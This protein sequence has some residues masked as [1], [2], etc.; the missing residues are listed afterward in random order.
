MDNIE[1][2]IEE[3]VEVDEV[4]ENDEPME[5]PKKSK[6][7][8]SPLQI[9]AMKKAQQVRMLKVAE[10]RTAILQEKQER[11]E[12]VKKIQTKNNTDTSSSSEEELQS[13]VS[14]PKPKPKR[15]VK[16]KAP[17]VVFEDSESDEEQEIVIRRV[18]RNKK[19]NVKPTSPINIPKK[20]NEIHLEPVEE[21][22]EPIVE[23]KKFSHR[24]ILRA[25]GM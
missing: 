15:K 11:E 5:K 13:P 8:R 20:E 22:I 12:R 21:E 6:K 9:E 3:P 1:E 10:K 16:K 24:E 25:M 17:K 14:K 19:E 4:K 2:P 23:E 7:N 18:R